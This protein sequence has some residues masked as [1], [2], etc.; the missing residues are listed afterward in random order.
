MKRPRPYIPLFIRVIVARR[1]CVENCGEESTASLD[2]TFRNHRTPK[3]QQ[4]YNYLWLAG[5]DDDFELDHYPALILRKFNPRT[6]RYTP[7]AND[8]NHLI[9]RTGAAHL[10]KTTGRKPGAAKTTDARDSDIWLKKKFARLEGRTKRRPK[11]KIPSR[12]FRSGK[13]SFPHVKR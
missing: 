4:I 1:Q 12:P 13:R 3:Q 11:R 9:Y 8:P 5:F 6:G 7:E 10:Q 2:E